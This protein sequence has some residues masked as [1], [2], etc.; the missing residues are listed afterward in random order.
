MRSWGYEK[1]AIRDTL[2]SHGKNYAFFL[3]FGT[4]TTAL[5]L[6]VRR[7]RGILLVPVW[8]SIVAAAMAHLVLNDLRATV[9]YV[10]V[11]L[12]KCHLSDWLILGLDQ[13][14]KELTKRVARLPKELPFSP[15]DADLS[16]LKRLGLMLAACLLLWLLPW[17]TREKDKKE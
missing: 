17:K 11:V 10:A 12:E 6:A 3:Q 15:S 13:S 7:I 9:L 5:T 8:I 2:K 16:A 14:G 4:C 1:Y